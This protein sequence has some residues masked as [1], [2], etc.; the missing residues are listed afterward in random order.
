MQAV[1]FVPL[2]H[3]DSDF[4]YNT[5]DELLI[6][7][8]IYIYICI[9][10]SDAHTYFFYNEF[11]TYIIFAYRIQVFLVMCFIIIGIIYLG[12]RMLWHTACTF[13]NCSNLVISLV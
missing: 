8:H 2:V 6:N 4:F 13:V 3:E 11:F 5:L 9:S 1:S 7:T 10:Y 12:N